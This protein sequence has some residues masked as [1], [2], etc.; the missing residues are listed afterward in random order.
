[1]TTKK[2]TIRTVHF[3]VNDVQD[4]NETPSNS[5]SLTVQGQDENLRTLY[6]RLLDGMSIGNESSA[7]YHD[8]NGNIDWDQIPSVQANMDRLTTLDAAKARI[9]EQI[10]VHEQLL[11]D[12][13]ATIAAKAR[14]KPLDKDGNPKTDDDDK[15]TTT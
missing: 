3:P 13:K 8:E 9:Q 11:E 15:T 10:D 5:E 7:V 4:R 14:H 12:H 1:M 6:N 2:R